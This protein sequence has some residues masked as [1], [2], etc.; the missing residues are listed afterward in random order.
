MLEVKELERGGTESSTRLSDFKSMLSTTVLKY[1]DQV[2]V[3]LTM[4]PVP[5]CGL[6][7]TKVL[8]LDPHACLYFRGKLVPLPTTWARLVKAGPGHLVNV[9]K[10]RFGC[11]IVPGVSDTE[12]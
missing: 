5:C 9:Q 6:L 12:F 4:S 7:N 11:P 10:P 2:R 1:F 8:D 3:V